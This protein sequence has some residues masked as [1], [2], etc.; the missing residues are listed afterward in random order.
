MSYL[1]LLLLSAQPM[2]AVDGVSAEQHVFCLPVSPVEE[3]LVYGQS[4]LATVYE[5]RG[6]RHEPTEVVSAVSGSAVLP[7]V[8]ERVV[9]VEK[10]LLFRTLGGNPLP[11]R[12]VPVREFEPRARTGT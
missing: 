8:L 11:V 6:D 2:V 1:F 10:P 9:E 5:D 4:H 12:G 7:K 3:V